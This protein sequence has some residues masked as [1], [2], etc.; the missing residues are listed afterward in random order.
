MTGNDASRA[1]LRDSQGISENWKGT[2]EYTRHPIFF[3][4]SFCSFLVKFTRLKEQARIFGN[5]GNFNGGVCRAKNLENLRKDSEKFRVLEVLID[6][7]VPANSG[8][9]EGSKGLP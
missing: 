2:S 8:V 5:E 6:S 1:L 9:I 7:R 4:F 3:L